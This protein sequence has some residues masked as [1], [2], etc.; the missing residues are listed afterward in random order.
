MTPINQ[1]AST[2]NI[3]KRLGCTSLQQAPRGRGNQG[4]GDRDESPFSRRGG[5]IVISHPFRGDVGD[6]DESPL[7]MRGVNVFCYKKN[8]PQSPY[9]TTQVAGKMNQ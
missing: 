4:K 6:R 5:R 8:C 9:H 3:H 2:C 1:I 7:P